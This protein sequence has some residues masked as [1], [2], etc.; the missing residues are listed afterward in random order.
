MPERKLEEIKER[1]PS[2]AEKISSLLKAL[3]V[4]DDQF[5]EQERMHLVEMG[6]MRLFIN[7]RVKLLGELYESLKVKAFHA[8]DCAARPQDKTEEDCDCGLTEVRKICAALAS[9]EALVNNR[10]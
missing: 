4:R 9:T 2:D 5:D 3:K 7:E 10:G 1:E 8:M 6:R